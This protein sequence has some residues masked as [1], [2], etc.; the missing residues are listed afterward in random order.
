M[1]VCRKFSE[2]VNLVTDTAGGTFTG[3]AGVGVKLRGVCASLHGVRRQYGRA[4]ETH[5]GTES[6]PPG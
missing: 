4:G 2:C 3:S 5:R 6:R 1:E